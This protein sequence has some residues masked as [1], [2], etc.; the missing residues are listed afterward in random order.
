MQERKNGILNL[1]LSI[2]AKATWTEVAHSQY[3]G[4]LSSCLKGLTDQFS[5]TA[6]LDCQ[7]EMFKA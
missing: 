7:G 3:G 6:V 4:R 1:K 5:D 2:L